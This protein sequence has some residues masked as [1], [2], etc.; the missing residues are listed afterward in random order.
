M[1][2][3]VGKSSAVVSG[4]EGDDRTIRFFERQIPITPDHLAG[5]AVV[6]PPAPAPTDVVKEAGRDQK[7][8]IRGRESMERRQA[9]EEAF[10]QEGHLFGVRNVTDVRVYPVTDAVDTGRLTLHRVRS[11]REIGAG[12]AESRAVSSP[13]FR[14]IE[15]WQMSKGKSCNRA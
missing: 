4:D 15:K 7:V 2:I 14:L 12:A 10:G 11:P 8:P 9:I 6:C 3:R 1:A 5:A 13:R